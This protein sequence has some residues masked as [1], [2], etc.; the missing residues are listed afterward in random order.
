MT[1]II[2]RD[3]EFYTG[4]AERAADNL[5]R[6]PVTQE[7]HYRDLE[8]AANG[9]LEALKRYRTLLGTHPLE[10]RWQCANC[11]HEIEPTTG[12][13]PGLTQQHL[14]TALQERFGPHMRVTVSPS[15]TD[16]DWGKWSAGVL[17]EAREGQV[18]E[19]IRTFLEAERQQIA[20]GFA[21]SLTFKFTKAPARVREII[22]QYGGRGSSIPVGPVVMHILQALLD[23]GI[24]T[25]P[26]IHMMLDDVG[27]R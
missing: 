6:C 23:K 19:E 4:E 16:R 18:A 25:E 20:G 27:V 24:L 17:V 21:W 2:N 12:L 10:G 5:R 3:I 1:S 11:R 15:K 26:E 8:S 7:T 14:E 22:A 13:Y 9:V